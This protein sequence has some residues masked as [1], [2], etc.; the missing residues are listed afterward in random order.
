MGRVFLDKYFIKIFHCNCSAWD[1]EGNNLRYSVL[2]SNV[3]SR[4][5]NLVKKYCGWLGGNWIDEERFTGRSNAC[6]CLLNF[7]VLFPSLTTAATISNEEIAEQLK[8]HRIDLIWTF[9]TMSG[10]HWPWWEGGGE[11]SGK[12]GEKRDTL[13]VE[14]S[15]GLWAGHPIFYIP[16]IVSNEINARRNISLYFRGLLSCYR[17]W[18]LRWLIL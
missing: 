6:F 4:T 11:G 14:A 7:V 1:C 12:G 5:K 3:I 18:V 13:V 8:L 2:R 10:G 15:S 16:G 9:M 17:L